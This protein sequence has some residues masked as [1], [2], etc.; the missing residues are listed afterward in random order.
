MKPVIPCTDRAFKY[1]DS[2]NTDIRK[3]FARLAREKSEREALE[4][5][6]IVSIPK[7]ATK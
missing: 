3:T 4:R 7:R 2:A 5:A 1:V 6:G